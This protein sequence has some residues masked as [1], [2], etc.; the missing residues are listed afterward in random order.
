MNFKLDDIRDSCKFDVSCQGSVPQAIKAFIES[1]SFED[2]IRTAISIGGDSVTIAASTGSIADPFYGV[3]DSPKEN[4]LS[5]LDDDLIKV[6]EE[7]Q[8]FIDK[9]I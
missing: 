8:A 9:Q 6:Y 7:W 1:T 3:P 4:A 5:Y 2:A